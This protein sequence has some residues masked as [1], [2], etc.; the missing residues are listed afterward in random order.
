MW[1]KG[2][3]TRP[4]AQ[5]CETLSAHCLVLVREVPVNLCKKE[6]L[7]ALLIIFVG[8]VLHS[9]QISPYEYLFLHAMPHE[10]VLA[11]NA[12]FC[13]EREGLKYVRCHC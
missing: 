4:F 6:V 8:L 7:L 9:C 10:Y 11:S 3:D 1:R 5:V 2:R 13:T 12:L